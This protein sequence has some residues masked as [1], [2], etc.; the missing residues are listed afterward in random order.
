MDTTVTTL[1][2]QSIGLGMVASFVTQL[3]KITE[4]IP[5]LSN[6]PPVQWVLDKVDSGN[7]ANIHICVAVIATLLNAVTLYVESGTVIS[8]AMLISTFGSFV[9]ALGTHNAVTTYAPKDS[10]IGA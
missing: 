2:G 4:S 8:V 10:P 3:I 9:M 6:F 5:W 7:D 1:L